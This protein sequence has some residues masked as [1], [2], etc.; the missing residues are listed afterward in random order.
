MG[1]RGLPVAGLFNTHVML[2][3]KRPAT[4][5]LRNATMH[6][7]FD[8]SNNWAPKP[9]FL[10]TTCFGTITALFDKRKIQVFKRAV[11]EPRYA[12]VTATS[13]CVKQ[14]RSGASAAKL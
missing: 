12:G 7:L 4:R 8:T 5:L 1:S 9:V 11:F 13:A 3:S 6:P 14:A 10:R 2:M